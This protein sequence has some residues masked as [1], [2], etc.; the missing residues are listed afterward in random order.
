MILNKFETKDAMVIEWELE[1]VT[2]KM[3]DW[4]WSNHE[5]CNILWHPAQHEALEWGI[6]PVDGNPIG[7]VHIA[8]QTWDDGKKQ[9]LYIQLRNVA[10]IDKQYHEYI[11]YNHVAIASCIGLG[12]GA[13][14]NPIPWGYRIHT[15]EAS[16]K[17]V[18]G[19]STAIGLKEPETHEQKLTWAAHAGEE[20]DNWAVFLPTLYNLYKVVTNP[21]WN[22]YADLTIERTNEGFR[23]KYIDLSNLSY[24]KK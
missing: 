14:K 20:V 7:S 1:G 2:A 5:K 22:P 11:K 24:I 8:P 18:I 15:W 19:Q 13:L 4:F 17:G 9:N 12:E 21:K 16:D 10:E 23:Y 6:P 3:I